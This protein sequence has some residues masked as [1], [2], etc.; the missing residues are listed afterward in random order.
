MMQPAAQL[1]LAAANDRFPANTV[2]AAKVAGQG[3]QG[4]RRGQR[5]RRPDAEHPADGVRVGRPRRGVG[6]L[7]EGLG[8]DSR[9]KRSFIGAQKSIA[10]KIG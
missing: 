4:L 3:R 7:D 10:Q 9:A 8:L 6:P 2:A 5:R 1:A